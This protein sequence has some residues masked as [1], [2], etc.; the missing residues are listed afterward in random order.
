MVSAQDCL[1]GRIYRRGIEPKSIE[2]ILLIASERLPWDL[3]PANFVTQ[4]LA[5]LL[6]VQQVY[7]TLTCFISSICNAQRSAVQTCI[8]WNVHTENTFLHGGYK[9]RLTYPLVC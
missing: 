1:A 7:V 5:K 2:C 9:K 6:V 4:V 3:V 8:I